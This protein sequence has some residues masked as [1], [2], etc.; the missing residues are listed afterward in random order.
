MLSEELVEAVGVVS[1]KMMGLVKWFNTRK[2]Y[3]FIQREDGGR[4]VFV[5]YTAIVASD[6]EFRD[7]REGQ[8]VEFDLSEGER[9]PIALNVV[10]VE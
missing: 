7:L 3:G 2:G 4:D 5:H 8:R 6:G 1:E 9:G 10:V